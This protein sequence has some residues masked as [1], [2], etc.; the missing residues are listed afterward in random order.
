MHAQKQYHDTNGYV[1]RVATRVHRRIK[2]SRSV[3]RTLSMCECVCMTMRTLYIVPI[4]GRL[5]RTLGN[6]CYG[7]T[8]RVHGS[9]ISESLAV[10]PLYGLFV[11]EGDHDHRD[12][13]NL[14]DLSPV[15]D[16]LRVQVRITIHTPVHAHPPSVPSLYMLYILYTV[17]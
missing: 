9:Y 15:Q 12:D 2:V 10:W 17:R 16:A 8:T 5:L 14:D 3:L 13:L 11:R 6:N 7:K 1:H 4:T